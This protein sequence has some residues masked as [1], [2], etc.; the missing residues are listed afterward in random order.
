MQCFRLP[1]LVHCYLRRPYPKTLVPDDSGSRIS[2]W[3]ASEC[4]YIFPSHHSNW[5]LC[6]WQENEG[7]ERPTTGIRSERNRSPFNLRC[8]KK[9]TKFL[10]DL[11]SL[12]SLTIHLDLKCDGRIGQVTLG[13]EGVLPLLLCIHSLQLQTSVVSKNK[14]EK[15]L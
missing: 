15:C 2:K 6:Q 8:A 5:S 14:T 13:I 12:L 1:I 9:D 11:G 3:G 7:K 10:T 4:G